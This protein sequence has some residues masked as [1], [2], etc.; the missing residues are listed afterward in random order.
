M[1]CPLDSVKMSPSINISYLSRGRQLG[2]DIPLRAT[3]SSSDMQP[4]N[5]HSQKQSPQQDLWPVLTATSARPHG[6]MLLQDVPSEAEDHLMQ[7]RGGGTERNKKSS[8]RA[9]EQLLKARL[10]NTAES[11]EQAQTQTQ[12]Q[13]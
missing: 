9:K 12:I 11:N 4:S 6:A 2:G 10:L 5:H 13:V 1:K 8:L 7:N 3:D